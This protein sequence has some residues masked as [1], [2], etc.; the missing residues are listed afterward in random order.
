MT[1]V[2]QRRHSRWYEQ[3]L[4]SGTFHLVLGFLLVVVLPVGLRYPQAIFSL[5]LPVTAVNS[6]YAISSAF[7]IFYISVRYLRNFPGAQSLGYAFPLLAASWLLVF[8]VLLFGRFEYA[9]QILFSSYLIANIWVLIG[10]FIRRK[11]RVLKLAVIP[12]GRAKCL[13]ET[14]RARICFLNKPTL[15][16]T[17]YDALVA[18]FHAK[19]LTPEWEKFIAQCVLARIPVFHYKQVEESLT[20]RVQIEHLSENEFGAL[21]P[22]AFYLATK[23]LLDTLLILVTLPL[24]LP[25]MLLVGLLIKL[26]SAGPMF[27]IQ[28]RI[29]FRNQP[30]KVYKLRSMYTNLKGKDFTPDQN[31]PRITKIGKF[32]RKTRIDE[33][34]QFLNVLKG[35]MSLIGPRPESKN[36]AIWYEEEIPFFSYRHVVR[37]GISGWAQVTQGY[38]AEIEAMNIK[39]EH[40]FYY[41]KHFSLSL[42]VLIFFQTLRTMLTGFGAR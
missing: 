30:F 26:E 32:I 41:I 14:N 37:P 25:L 23:R 5:N 18:D 28:E 21:L 4:F 8:A 3:V 2:F 20:G 22:S 29:G 19:E 10:F 16:S 12:L 31:D 15:N 35:E 38:A 1:S 24:W 13:A 9:R 7:V 34:P 42:D 17:R 6:A 27:F 11:Y 36:L 40:D 39:L 33:L